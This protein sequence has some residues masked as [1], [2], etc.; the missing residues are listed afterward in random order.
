MG[1]HCRAGGFEEG[2]T[3]RGR[4]IELGRVAGEEIFVARS[5]AGDIRF[6]EIG[7]RSEGFSGELE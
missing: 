3:R 6:D 5:T 4:A 7:G 2:P 1:R